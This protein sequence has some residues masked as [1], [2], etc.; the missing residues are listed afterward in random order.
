[1]EQ[2]TEIDY[3]MLQ[4]DS[5]RTPQLISTLALYD[6]ST[7]GGGQLDFAAIRDTFSRVVKK[8]AVFR[9]RVSD[10]A[11]GWDT[12]FWV[13]DANFDLDFHL[14][15]IALPQPGDWRQLCNQASRLHAN[16]LDMSRPLWE[17]YVIEGLDAIDGLPKGSFAVMLK[18]HH[19]AVDGVAV[20]RLLDLL[21]GQDRNAGE[22][23]DIE[24]DWEGEDE[25]TIR[26][27]WS[28]A[29][30]NSKRRRRKMMETIWAMAPKVARSSMK[31]DKDKKNESKPFRTIFNEQ[32]SSRRIVGA[33]FLR[34]EQLKEIRSAIP[35]V[36]INDIA[37]SVVGGA[38]RKYLIERGQMPEKDLV[39]SAPISVREDFEGDVL[40]NEVGNMNVR[41][42]VD[43]ADPIERL[44]AVHESA[45]DAKQRAEELGKRTMLDLTNSV[46]PTI[47]GLS[48]KLISLM[49]GAKDTTFPVQTIVSN[50]P[51]PREPRFM[52][53]CELHSVMAFGPLMDGLG[54]FHGLVSAGGRIPI[55][56]CACGD[57]MED[58]E[59]Y[60]QCLRQSWDELENAVKAL[61]ASEAAASAPPAK[62]RRKATGSAKHGALGT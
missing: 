29:Y 58:A 39:T 12:P 17:A 10:K 46:S 45:K 38:M 20:A 61:P 52:A 1:M 33:H 11:H 40:G 28:K 27:V 60:E 53:G 35:G 9:R 43:I 30:A 41:L 18:L 44:T 14:R 36:T 51:G 55:A 47:I 19:A 62:K 13:N 8:S 21:N 25:P 22:T 26:Q 32:V 4:M 16:Q 7:L 59:F 5:A 57:I 2:L 42:G 23:P 34:L 37:I 31:K 3:A 49:A 54:I 6:A 50:V 48:V 15:H 24:D 56:F